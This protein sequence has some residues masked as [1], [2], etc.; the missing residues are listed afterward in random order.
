MGDKQGQQQKNE[1][2]NTEISEKKS[3]YDASSFTCVNQSR[4]TPGGAIR[5]DP[6][7]KKN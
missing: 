3:Q 1:N 5:G 7:A 2:M 6:I 4:P